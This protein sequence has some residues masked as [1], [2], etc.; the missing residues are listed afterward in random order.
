M[1]L[2]LYMQSKAQAELVYGEK[3]AS[4]LFDNC[5]TMCFLGSNTPD[6]LEDVSKSIGEETVYARITNRTF[7]SGAVPQSSSESI[8]SQGRAVL[9][10][11][12]LRKMPNDELVVQISGL[13]IIRDKKFRTNRHPYYCYVSSS[14]PRSILMPLPRFAERFDFEEY[15]RRREAE[16][17]G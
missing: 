14:Y 3:E 10:V 2:S 4:V 8:Q 7:G 9:S 11:A 16:R 5:S 6:V 15:R 17:M 12:Q 1:S 13:P